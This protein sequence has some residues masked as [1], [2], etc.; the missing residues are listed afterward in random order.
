MSVCVCG[1]QHNYEV[2]SGAVL[3]DTTPDLLTSGSGRGPMHTDA[4]TLA[5]MLQQQLDVINNEIRSHH[6]TRHV[7]S[8]TSRHSPCSLTYTASHQSHHITRRA[9]SHTPRHISHITCRALSHTPCHISHITSLAVL[10]HIHRVTSVTSRHSPCSL[11]YTASHQS[12][13]VTHRALSHTPSSDITSLAVLSHVHRVTSRH[14]TS[15]A[16]L[17]HT[18]RVTSV[19]PRHSPCSLTHTASHQSHHVTRRALSHTCLLY[20]SPSPRD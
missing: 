8:V 5:M 14:I 9:L 12:H 4:Q 11:T 2:D 1:M 16:V 10:S 19:T 3:N 18:H 15:L 6:V 17:S 13:H 20:T 7:T